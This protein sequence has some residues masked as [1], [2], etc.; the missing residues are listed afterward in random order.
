[1]SNSDYLGVP[2]PSAVGPLGSDGPNKL[3]DLALTGLFLLFQ[4]IVICQPRCDS[5]TE[6]SWVKTHV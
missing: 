1:M 3:S 6:C 5:A 4:P 2:L